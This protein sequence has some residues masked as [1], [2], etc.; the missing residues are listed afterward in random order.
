MVGYHE[1]FG[2][3]LWQWRNKKSTLWAS[4]PRCGRGQSRDVVSRNKGLCSL[5]ALQQVEAVTVGLLKLLSNAK[6]HR[7][8]GHEVQEWADKN[9]IPWHFCLSYSPTAAGLTEGPVD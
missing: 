8:G 5:H 3:D 4:G 9:A 2:W 6:K 1:G 7:F